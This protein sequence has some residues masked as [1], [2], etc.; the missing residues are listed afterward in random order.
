MATVP[1]HVRLHLADEVVDF[2]S[3]SNLYA[4]CQAE[5]LAYALRDFI[6]SLLGRGPRK[7]CKNDLDDQT[8]CN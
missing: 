7:N 4:L 6:C 1:T 2:S 8:C 3:T 5:S